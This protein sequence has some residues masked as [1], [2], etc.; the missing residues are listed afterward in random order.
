MNL[1]RSEGGMARA[2]RG[3]YD[4][5]AAHYHLIF[6]D[7]E[8]SMARQAAALAPVVERECGA[9]ARV[10]DCACGIGTQLLGLA[11]RGFRVSG[12]D[13][14]RGAVRRARAEAAERQADVRLYVADL[15]KLESVPESGFDAIVCLDN[16]LPHLDSDAELAVAARQVFRKLRPGGVFIAS[17]R[18]YERLIVERPVVHGPAFFS[19]GG[20]RRIVFQ[21]WEWKDERRYTFHLHV[22]WET[23]RGWRSI[24]GAAAYRAVL[25]AE[26]GA[27]IEGAGFTRVRWVMPEESGF[28]QPLVIAAAP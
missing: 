3:F 6:E 7:W 13:V 14:S 5:F 24:H 28:Y 4:R 22:T 10:L 12:S 19:D 9:G 16:A 20:M 2:V 26:L 17:I 11:K 21:V 1:A 27:I 25:R 15:L 18:D 8:A 23:A